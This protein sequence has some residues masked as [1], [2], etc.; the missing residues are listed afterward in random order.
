MTRR[1]ERRSAVRHGL[2]AAVV[3]TALAAL[4]VG[5]CA[6]CSIGPAASD[7]SGG[8]SATGSTRTLGEQ[9]EDVVNAYCQTAL[10]RCAIASTFGDCTDTEMGSCCSGSACDAQSTVSEATVT[11]CEQTIDNEDCYLI[12][13]DTPGSCLQ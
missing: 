2:G 4:F 11:A 8:G 13:Q 10:G 5:G 12:T 9:C 6:G 7:S 3:R 1:S